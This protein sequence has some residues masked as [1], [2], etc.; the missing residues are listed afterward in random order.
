MPCTMW[1]GE[2]L[3]PNLCLKALSPW[4]STLVTVLNIVQLSTPLSVVLPS[5]FFCF[6]FFNSSHL[7]CYLLILFLFLSS[8]SPLS[9]SAWW[10]DQFF[11]LFTDM[12]PKGLEL[13]LVNRKHKVGACWEIFGRFSI[14]TRSGR[15]RLVSSFNSATCFHKDLSDS[16]VQGHWEWTGYLVGNK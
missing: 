7:T 16:D 6:F 14:S 3:A 8:L 11:V 12:C 5:L 10:E 15:L 4:G 9:T 1:V 2:S 13:F